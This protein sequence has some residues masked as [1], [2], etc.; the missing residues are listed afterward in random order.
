MDRQSYN[1][2]GPGHPRRQSSPS[3]ND[4]SR[5]TRNQGWDENQRLA[6]PPPQVSERKVPEPKRT[7]QSLNWF[8]FWVWELA[9]LALICIAL[10]ALVVTLYPHQG[11]PLPEWPFDIS[12]NA[13]LSIYSLVFKGALLFVVAS[14]LGQLQWK[15]FSS[16]RP[17]YDLV[18]YDEATRGPWGSVVLLWSQKFRQPLTTLAIALTVAAVAIDP[19]IQQFISLTDCSAVLTSESSTIPRTSLFNPMTASLGNEA[20]MSSEELEVALNARVNSQTSEITSE[21]TT[22]NCTFTQ[23]YSTLGYCGYC[24]D[25]S[26]DIVFNQTC[27]Q[28]NRTESRHG[29]GAYS[30][31]QDCATGQFENISSTLPS[32]VSSVFSSEIQIGESV[33]LLKMDFHEED[34]AD[35][36]DPVGSV[37]AFRADLLVGKTIMSGKGIDILTGKNFTDCNGTAS[38]NTWRCRGYGAATCRLQPCVRRYNA[39]VTAGRLT[40]QLLDY[41]PD[42]PWGSGHHTT[43]GSSS[44]W[45]LLDT[46]CVS[47]EEEARVVEQG[48]H[49]NGSTPWIPFN[50]TSP[51]S[52]SNEDTGELLQ[53]LLEKKC[54][55]LVGEGFTSSLGSHMAFKLGTIKG[56]IGGASLTAGQGAGV[57]QGPPMLQRIYDYGRVDLDHIQSTYN[58][59]AEGLTEYIRMHGNASFSEPATGQVHHFATCLNVTWQWIAFPAVLSLATLVLFVLTVAT[60]TAQKMP[61]WKSSPL[62]WICRGPTTAGWSSRDE[63]DGPPLTKHGMEAWSKTFAVKL[64]GRDDPVIKRDLMPYASRREHWIGR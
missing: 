47:A 7:A 19:I 43:M 8:G 59:I 46:R 41:S 20:A 60:T 11:K 45:A 40:E 24:K 22:G 6:K 55:F 35:V 38:K 57:P 52:A 5:R 54:L 16:E 13:L 50:I 17:L 34:Y 10:V 30:Y 64:S 14:C 1:L 26:H 27:Y 32:G 44:F 63:G 58:L 48:Y 4:G 36:S 61:V 12:I 2:L 62:A 25:S 31:F 33:D 51:L 37:T 18:R 53:S 15:W 42:I 9:A 28:H 56:V 3:R 39:T 23:V 49:M 21:C 29:Y